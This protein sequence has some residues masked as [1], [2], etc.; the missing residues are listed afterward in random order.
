MARKYQ[1]KRRADKA[2]ETRKRILEAIVGLHMEVGPAKTTV[3]AIAEAAGV[4][5]LT[6]YRYFP[7]AIS[8]YRAC[9]AHW[10]GLHPHPD[11]TRWAA[12]PDPVERLSAALLEMYVFYRETAPMTAN[13]LRDEAVL[14]ELAA[15]ANLAR[16]LASMAE[17]LAETWAGPE[18]ARVRPMI[19]LAFS[20]QT[21]QQL[22]DAHGLTDA[23]IVSMMVAAIL[24]Q[25]Q[26]DA[27]KDRSG[28]ASDSRH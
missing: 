1:L 12:I 13:I 4:E 17:L 10:T 27:D 28:Q 25:S 5:R 20:F 8:M 16:R 3:S 24:A 7:D 26:D 18:V 23:E 22:A 11:V 21:W 9:G 15:T 19:A 14:P 6:V 2:L